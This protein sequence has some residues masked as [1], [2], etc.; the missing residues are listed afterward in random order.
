MKKGIFRSRFLIMLFATT[1]HISVAVPA[2]DLDLRTLIAGIKHFDAA[3][4][5]GS[6][7][8]VYDRQMGS[9]KE[10][11]TYVLTFD[12]T[13]FE[14]AQVRVDVSKVTGLTQIFTDICDGERH[15]QVVER[16]TPLFDVEIS[17]ADS[18]RLNTAKPELPHAVKQK[19]KEVGVN[20]SGDFRIET[21]EGSP[22]SKW[23]DNVTGDSYIIHA[24]EERV[25][26][27]IPG[28][29]Y[30]VG[31]GCRINALLDPRY[32]MTS[33]K[34]TPTSYLM[35]PLWRVLEKYESEI[36][37]T[38]LINGDETYLVRVKVPRGAP[39][40]FW[41][42]PEKG[43]RLVKSQTMFEHLIESDMIPLKK[44]VHYLTE[45]VLHYREY[46]PGIWFPEK[47]EETFHALVAEDPEN[48]ADIIGNTTLQLSGAFQLN[49]DV[50]TEFQ[51]EVPAETPIY[52]S[53]LDKLR[54]FRELRETSQ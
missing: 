50:S 42:C 4:T 31:P 51:L 3:V 11:K 54:P 1:C 28:I 29:G 39:L 46:Q 19:F 15:W 24:T 12:G 22:H 38:E 36:L 27:D 25:W 35:T 17:P 14:D 49:L 33:G 21:E 10:K 32:W 8:I 2:P 37:K 52:D 13:T 16:N 30:T 20:V 18:Q 9:T 23:I 7:E 26:V 43:F 5:S 34:A 40:K 44:G 41:I 53:V 45:R 47:I 6:G 48:R